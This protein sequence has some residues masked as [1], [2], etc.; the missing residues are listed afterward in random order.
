[1]RDAGRTGTKPIAGLHICPECGSNLVQPT[2]WEQTDERGHWRLWRRCPECG[3]RC[4]SVHGEGEIEA[5]DRELDGGTETLAG[6]LRELERE[7]MRQLAETFI[8]AL[9]ADLIGA[10]D[11][12]PP[13]RGRAQL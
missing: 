9:A 6:L 12:A 13:V 2:C 8:A 1:M 11:F 7:N 5:Y 10:E 3:W 4:D